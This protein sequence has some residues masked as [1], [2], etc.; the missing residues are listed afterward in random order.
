MVVARLIETAG[1]S[2]RR[3]RS[4][5]VG[6]A[7]RDIVSKLV[8]CAGKSSLERVRVCVQLIDEGRAVLLGSILTLFAKRH[9]VWI[10]FAFCRWP[11][12]DILA[13]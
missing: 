5:H 3:C 9:H 7:K 6:L 13:H 2:L 4:H 8:K 11:H 1:G 10:S 12:S